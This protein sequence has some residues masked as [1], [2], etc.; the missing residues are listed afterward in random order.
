MSTEIYNPT[1]EDLSYENLLRF[2]GTAH[3]LHYALYEYITTD[4]LPVRWPSRWN[5]EDVI[6][7][8]QRDNLSHMFALQENTKALKALQSILDK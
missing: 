4:R 3:K 8:Y 1:S 6:F 7:L 5:M 2:F